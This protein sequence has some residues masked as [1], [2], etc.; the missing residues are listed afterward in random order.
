MKDPRL[1]CEGAL[2][3]EHV[4]NFYI[5]YDNLIYVHFRIDHFLSISNLHALTD[6]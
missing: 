3:L 5:S 4:I 1:A 6:Q 2:S